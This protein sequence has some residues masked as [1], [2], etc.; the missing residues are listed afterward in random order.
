MAAKAYEITPV[1]FFY[2]CEATACDDISEDRIIEIAAV[3]YTKNLPKYGL[4]SSDIAKL[5]ADHFQSLCHCTRPIKPIVEEKV[6]LSLADLAGKPPLH[7]V[8]EWFFT[9]INEKMSFVNKSSISSGRHTPVLVAH[10]GRKLD[11][12]I[13]MA[14]LERI[15][16]RPL[17]D[18]HGYT[19]VG[20]S[21]LVQLLDNLSLHFAD[22]Y[23]MCKLLRTKLGSILY[24]VPSLSVEA[25][26]KHFFPHEPFDAHRA[27]PDAQILRKLF[28]DSP[29]ASTVD[30]ELTDT[31]EDTKTTYKKWKQIEIMKAG[32][33]F[34]KA[35]ELVFMRGITLRQLEQQYRQNPW[36]FLVYLSTL[37]IRRP[38]QK[39][40]DYFYKL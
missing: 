7:T 6:G 18:K 38:N 27:L 30:R 25:L 14:E 19:N 17:Y 1:Y 29:L 34:H 4:S 12:P 15:N 24:E 10:S 21:S 20:S 31:I 2:D 26:Y 8:L 39:L 23:T 13:L 5:D 32:I 33:T 37:G 35:G 16:E 40:M 22:T 9:W 3:L 28:T 36:G 11:F